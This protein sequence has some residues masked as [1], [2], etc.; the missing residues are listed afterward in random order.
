MNLDERYIT[1]QDKRIRS[2]KDKELLTLLNK[3]RQ[4]KMKAERQ[5]WELIIQSEITED[6]LQRRNGY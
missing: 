2:L 6:E 1:D 3:I 5:V 4:Q